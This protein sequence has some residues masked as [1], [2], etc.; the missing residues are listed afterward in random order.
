MIATGKQMRGN[1]FHLNPKMN[2]CLIAKIDDSWLWHTRFCDINFDN[3][4]K[5]SKSKI[6][7]GLPQLDKLVN[8]LCKEC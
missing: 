5:V 4:I 2:N 7:R 3:I 1:L 6:V 8:A